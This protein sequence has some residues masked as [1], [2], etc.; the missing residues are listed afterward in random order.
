MQRMNQMVDQP[1][2][3]FIPVHADAFLHPLPHFARDLKRGGSTK[4]VAFGSSSTA[5]EG[6]IVP[7]PHRLETALRAKYGGRMIDV[8]NRGKGGDEAPGELVRMQDDVIAENP[9]LVVW[10][11][12]TNA[13]WQLGHDLDVVGTAIERGLKMLL[14]GGRRDVVLMDLQ[15]APALV[16]DDKMDATTRMLSAISACADAAGV[17]L[18][19]RFGFMRRCH[20]IEKI[21]FDRMIDPTDV[22]RLHQSDWSARR[23]AYELSEAIAAAASLAA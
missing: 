22:E 17:N 14:D 8:L 6:E 23:I 10:Q 21:S 4:I 11:V 18:F 1:N 3:K 19:R 5:G 12:G 20:E 16:T 13:V 9:T 7:Y 15:F 2:N